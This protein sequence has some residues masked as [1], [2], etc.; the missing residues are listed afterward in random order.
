MPGYSIG[1]K[2]QFD[3]FNRA[4]GILFDATFAGWIG[5]PGIGLAYVTFYVYRKVG[6][7]I[8]KKGLRHILCLR[9][10]RCK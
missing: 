8:K 1:S 2:N 10:R 6:A 3:P 9:Y 7:N 4:D 5:L